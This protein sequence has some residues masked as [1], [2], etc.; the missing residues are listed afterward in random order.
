MGRICRDLVVS[1]LLAGALFTLPGWAAE[2]V[3]LYPAPGGLAVVHP[4]T[5]DALVLGFDEAGEAEVR[6][7]A[8][9]VWGTPERSGH[10]EECGAGPVDYA[11]FDNGLMLY[12]QDDLFIGWFLEEQAT[13]TTRDG[14]GSG[15]TLAEISEFLPDVEII[16]TTL[17][18]E[19]WG[20]DLFG[21]VD[22]ERPDD[23]VAALWSGIVC[24]FR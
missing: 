16:E 11:Y 8:T 17:G 13:I 18:I 15:S 24:L 12:F 2:G 1:G 22:G 5:G 19:F 3:R 23:R 21:V 9:K 14:L 7:S 4:A 10:M 6:K 20:E